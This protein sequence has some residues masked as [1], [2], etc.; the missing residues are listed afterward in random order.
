[1]TRREELEARANKIG[2][3]PSNLSEEILD[4]LLQ[5]EREVWEKVAQH[6][7]DN[8]DDFTTF[9]NHGHGIV[10]VEFLVERFADW[11]REQQYRQ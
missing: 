3:G 7:V 5:V 1:M 9:V 2:S 4:A 11:C 10:G 6:I 8:E